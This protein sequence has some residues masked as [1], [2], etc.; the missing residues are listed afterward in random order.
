MNNVLGTTVLLTDPNRA[1]TATELTNLIN[2][3]AT[4]CGASCPANRTATVVS[5]ACA[6]LSGS[7]ATL[8]E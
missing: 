6:A 2:S 7:A 8:V 4:S 1:Q 5:A 3:L